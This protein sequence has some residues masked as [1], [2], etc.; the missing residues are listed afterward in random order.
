M[1]VPTIDG[2]NTE[3]GLL[4][5]MLDDGTQEWRE[6]LG[7]I[8]RET[9]VWQPVP[10]GHSI[11]VLILHIADVEAYWLHQI[12]AGERLSP[13]L[14]ATLMGDATDQYAGI[15]PSPH[16]Q[17]LAWYLEQ[18]DAIRARTREIV[19]RINAPEHLGRRHSKAQGSETEFT[20]RWLLHHVLTHEAY[21]GGQ[22]VLL[23][24]QYK[25]R[26]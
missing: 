1:D 19:S 21:H 8:E 17:P 10:S 7:E 15:W 11:G 26:L 20:L 16:Q 22:A 5:A 23:A 3:I 14:S 24:Q 2:L 6:E 18:H 4:L 12:A 9:V 25:C 13:E